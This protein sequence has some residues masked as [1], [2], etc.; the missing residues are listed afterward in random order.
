MFDLAAPIVPGKSAAGIKLG[1]SIDEIIKFH[2]PVEIHSLG[3]GAK[4]CFNQIDL[5]VRNGKVVQISVKFDYLGNVQNKIGIG[6]TI[7]DVQSAFGKVMED[8]EDN[9]IVP[10]IP[11][12]CFETETW[13]NGQ[14][15]SENL[16]SRITEIFVFIENE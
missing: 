13:Q 16:N 8:E 6:A 10:S 15:I 4:Y 5:W 1:Q 12:W 2:Q 7:N 3:D 14:E 9:L 11:G